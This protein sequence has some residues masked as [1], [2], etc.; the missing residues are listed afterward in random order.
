MPA[1]ETQVERLGTTLHL[2]SSES[3]G[4]QAIV[5][6]HGAALDHHSFD[7]QLAALTAGGFRVITWDLR[8]HGA[9]Q[10][11]GEPFRLETAA[12][13]LLAVMDAVGLSSCFLAGHSFGGCVVQRVAALAPARVRGLVIE[14]CTDLSAKPSLLLTAL[15]KLAPARVARMSLEQ[16]RAESVKALSLRPEVTAQAFAATAALEHA[17]YVEVIMAGLDCLTRDSGLGQDYR[18]PCPTL[19]IYGEQDKANGGI[20]PRASRAWAR[21]DPSARQVPIPDAGHTAHQD[22]PTAFNSAVLAFL[23]EAAG[24]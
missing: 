18:L 1:M 3:R 24:G 12:A 9:S 11:M 15:A 6:T 13:A 10:P 2:W 7:Q 23:S 19:L 16:L 14:G 5:L 20:F 21:R 17:A 8:G 22:N 4:D